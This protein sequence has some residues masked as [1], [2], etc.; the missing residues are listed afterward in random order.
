[1]SW[2]T[3]LISG[4][5]ARASSLS[6]GKRHGI[7]AGF[8]E[9]GRSPRHLR[10]RQPQSSEPAPRRFDR[11]LRVVSSADR[12]GRVAVA[13]I[14]GVAYRYRTRIPTWTYE[15]HLQAVSQAELGGL[16]R[17]STTLTAGPPASCERV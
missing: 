14:G 7:S 9:P 5:A 4:F 1:M 2:I 16:A 8:A 17:Q 15:K 13:R 11:L 10:R 12:R 3:F 6:C